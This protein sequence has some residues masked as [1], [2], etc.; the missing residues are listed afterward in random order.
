VLTLLATALGREK[1]VELARRTETEER[2]ELQ[3]RAEPEMQQVVFCSGR[4]SVSLHACAY[5][6]PGTE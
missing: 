2:G 3:R 5:V 4:W 1:N 6:K